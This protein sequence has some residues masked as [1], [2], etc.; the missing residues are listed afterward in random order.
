MKDKTVPGWVKA[1]LV[2]GLCG[3]LLWRELRAPA[4]RSRES[5]TLHTARN[6]A[7]AGIAGLAVEYA[8]APVA[9]HLARLTEKRR[10][11]I[12]KWLS[13]PAW[14]EIPLA[15]LALDYTLYHWH[16]QCHKNHFL[17]R[18]HEPHHADLDMDASTALRFHF[19]EVSLSV[20]WRALQVVVIGVSPL[21]FSVWQTTLVLSIL[22]HHSNVR[23]SAKSEGRLG[24]VLITP[25]MHAIHHSNVREE[26]DSNWSSSFSFWDR[27]H[28][29][30]RLGVPPEELTIGVP[31]HGKPED[32]TLSKVL[33]MPF[34]EQRPS[35][36]L[37]DGTLR[38]TRESAAGVTIDVAPSN[39]LDQP[40]MRS[41]GF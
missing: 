1:P 3:W 12:L 17:W 16:R 6:L 25:R 10:W 34:V 21:A 37:P 41:K 31:A 24:N 5:K 35:W 18:F 19:G 2:A 28:G 40:E 11:G 22:F 30:L 9:L 4:R 26:A 15:V 39:G 32:V 38:I 27:I 20:G 29:T 14:L 33:E 23:L 36:R 8:E 13:L 7:I